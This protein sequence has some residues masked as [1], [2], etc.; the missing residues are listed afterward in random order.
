[1]Y[2]A[3]VLGGP[4]WIQLV[5]G[6]NCGKNCIYNIKTS[7]GMPGFRARKADYTAQ[8]LQPELQRLA[9]DLKV[10]PDALTLEDID[11]RAKLL[12]SNDFY[13]LQGSQ[14]AVDDPNTL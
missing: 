6:K 13:F 3:V 12:R 1:M 4:K 8:D 11:A 10:N 5:A 7:S 14:L 2:L 9:D